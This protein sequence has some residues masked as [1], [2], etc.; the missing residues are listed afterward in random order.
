MYGQ[1][2]WNA[3]WS[4]RIPWKL[5]HLIPTQQKF[6]PKPQKDITGSQQARNTAGTQLLSNLIPS[7]N[8]VKLKSAISEGI[9]S[10]QN[11]YNTTTFHIFNCG[12]V[13]LRQ[14]QLFTLRYTVMFFK[15]K[16]DN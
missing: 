15:G 9:Y 16:E 10:N 8:H 12:I 5:C 7:W 11:T 13:G 3:D 6:I 2:P 14:C 1:K 4:T